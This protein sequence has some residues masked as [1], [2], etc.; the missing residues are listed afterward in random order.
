VELVAQRVRDLVRDRQLTQGQFDALVSATFN[1]GRDDNGRLLEAA[2]RGD[3]A[4]VFSQLR[5]LVHTHDHDAQGHTVG[6]ARRDPGLVRRGEDEIRQY[7]G[8]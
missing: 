1:T 7:R 3:D 2:N 8:Q 5:N 6:P 4:G